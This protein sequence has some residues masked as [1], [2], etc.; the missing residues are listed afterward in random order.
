[1]TAREKAGTPWV[2][3]SA[4]QR[5]V[6]SLEEEPE[7]RVAELPAVSEGLWPGGVGIGAKLS[8]DFVSSD[9]TETHFFLLFVLRYY[10]RIMRYWQK[11]FNPLTAE[12]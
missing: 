7:D 6:L 1:M 12:D 9:L 3:C 2:C 11:A 8:A 4:L 5:P 10:M